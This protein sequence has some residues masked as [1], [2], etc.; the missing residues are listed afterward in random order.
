MIRK[1]LYKETELFGIKEKTKKNKK[2][3]HYDDDIKSCEVSLTIYEFEPSARNILFFHELKETNINYFLSFP[4]F[5]VIVAF[6]KKNSNG[7]VFAG[8]TKT[9]YDPTTN[10]NCYVPP[11]PNCYRSFAVCGINATHDNV[12]DLFWNSSFHGDAYDGNEYLQKSSMKN[13][14][15]WQKMSK[16]APSFILS[17]GCNYGNNPKP[18]IPTILKEL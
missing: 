6:V 7:L 5:Q 13:L 17:E 9:P 3:Y 4:Y 1:I 8:M 2:F 11:L 16:I 12:A 14:N 10:P 15:V 18:L